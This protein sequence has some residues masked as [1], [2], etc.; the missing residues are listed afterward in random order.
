MSCTTGPTG[1][2]QE[3]EPSEDDGVHMSM[4]KKQKMLRRW[5]EESRLL[6]RLAFPA[7]LTEVLQFS[8]GFVT[9]SFVGHLGEVELAAV[10]VVENI[11]DSSAYG[12]LF[13]MGSALD[14]LSGQAVGAGQLHRLGTYTQQSVD[15]LRRHGGGAV[16]GVRARAPLLRSVLHQPAAVA[17]AAGPYARWA[18]PRLF[19]HAANIPTLMFFQAQGS[20]WPAAAIS[21]AALAAHAALTYAAVVRLGYGLRGA[22]VAG[23]VSHWLVV[24]AQ[25]A[26][27]TGGRF[28]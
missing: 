16:A 10:T 23:N 24:A 5:W 3:N 6:W 21:G 28:P 26:Y 27:M 11:L 1:L 2:G 25:L 8:I 9:T 22:A 12:V 15:H 17:A 14:T 19:A 20:L 4:K 18:I 7:L 13:G